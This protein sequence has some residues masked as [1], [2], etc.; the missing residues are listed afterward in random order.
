VCNEILVKLDRGTIASSLEARSPLLDDRI[1]EFGLSL[2]LEFKRT[3]NAKDLLQLSDR[4]DR[5]R[6]KAW[7]AF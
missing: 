4:N 7:V 1:V 2:P 6:E 3:R 5:E